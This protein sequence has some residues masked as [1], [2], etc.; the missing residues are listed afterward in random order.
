MSNLVDAGPS[1]VRISAPSLA[2]LV[3]AVTAAA[4]SASAP[5]ALRVLADAA[6][7]VSGAEVAVA[8]SGVRLVRMHV[9]GP[10]VKIVCHSGLL[11]HTPYPICRNQGR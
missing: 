1:D 7:T 6:R 11:Y 8:V 3:R 5:E 2:A 4:V 10:A 9:M